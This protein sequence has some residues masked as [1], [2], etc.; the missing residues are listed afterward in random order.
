MRVGRIRGELISTGHR[1]THKCQVC[2]YLKGKV[3]TAQLWCRNCKI[4]TCTQ[5]CMHW[6]HHQ[7][8]FP[9]AY[10]APNPLTKAAN[11]RKQKRTTPAKGTPTRPAKR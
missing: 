10:Y 8:V 5:D 3:I 2:R 6:W 7:Y 1:N 11:R 4:A 9:Q